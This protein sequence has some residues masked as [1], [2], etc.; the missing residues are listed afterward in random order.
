MKKRASSAEQHS[1]NIPRDVNRKMSLW[2][3]ELPYQNI[4]FGLSSLF[5]CQKYRLRKEASV[6]IILKTLGFWIKMDFKGN[7]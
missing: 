4:S 3:V 5:L 1:S 2:A 6:T 7:H